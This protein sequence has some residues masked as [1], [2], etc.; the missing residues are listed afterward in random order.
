MIET[1]SKPSSAKK[2]A[3]KTSFWCRMEIKQHEHV[4]K[5]C[6]SAGKNYYEA[7]LKEAR[8]TTSWQ[9]M[10]AKASTQSAEAMKTYYEELFKVKIKTEEMRI[11]L[12]FKEEEVIRE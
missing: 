5:A 12:M 7:S 6:A 11:T 1:G 8:V 9:R 3:Q 2:R 10:A 4:A